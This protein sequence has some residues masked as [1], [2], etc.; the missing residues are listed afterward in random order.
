MFFSSD[1]YKWLA[2]E[3][4]L[5]MQGNLQT[6]LV[7][8]VAFCFDALLRMRVKLQTLNLEVTG[9]NPVGSAPVES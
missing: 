8:L 2:W 4:E 6:R 9:S 1:G 5:P 3:I 7:N